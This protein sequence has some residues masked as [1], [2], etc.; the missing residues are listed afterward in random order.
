[1]QILQ[2]GDLICFGQST[3]KF[4]NDDNSVHVFRLKLREPVE[5]T[6][7]LSDDD[8]EA[9]DIKPVKLEIKIENETENTYSIDSPDNITIDNASGSFNELETGFDSENYS[10]EIPDEAHDWQRA[11]MFMDRL[12]FGQPNE[13]NDVIVVKTTAQSTP[14]STAPPSISLNFVPNIVLSDVDTIKIKEEVGWNTYQY[15]KTLRQEIAEPEIEETIDLCSDNEEMDSSTVQNEALD[16]SSTQKR[17]RKH[18]SMDDEYEIKLPEIQT[19]RICADKPPTMK[20][21]VQE[22][23]ESE[24]NRLINA[25]QLNPECLKVKAHVVTHSR[26]NRLALDMLGVD[27]GESAPIATEKHKSSSQIGIIHRRKVDSMTEPMLENDGSYPC[28]WSNYT[29]ANRLISEITS[30]NVQW[31]LEQ[32]SD[33]PVCSDDFTPYPIPTNFDLLRTYQEVWGNFAKLALWESILIQH[34]RENTNRAVFLYLMDV[35]YVK[36]YDNSARFI[37]FCEA[38]IDANDMRSILYVDH[39]VLVVH[40][41]GKFLAIIT[42]MK[43]ARGE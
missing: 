19:K 20:K 22:L 34:R 39:L 7:A 37:Y 6:I 23:P 14:L 33:A 17:H 13:E 11:E 36:R 38:E 29:C 32:K 2:D 16:A 18:K 8:G 35:K 4:D 15:E 3:F 21:T 12:D 31:L 10:P 42:D 40:G 9:L 26:G 5:E 28:K 1:M 41:N 25:V 30:W 27:I 24:K 43:F